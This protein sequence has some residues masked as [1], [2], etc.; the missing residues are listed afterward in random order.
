[1]ITVDDKPLCSKD[2]LHRLGIEPGGGDAVSALW[3]LMRQG[4]I[5]RQETFVYELKKGDV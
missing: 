1:M 3:S 2:L 5:R 4:I